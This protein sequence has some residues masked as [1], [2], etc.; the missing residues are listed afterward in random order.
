MANEPTAKQSTPELVG[1][2]SKE[3]LSDLEDLNRLY[4]SLTP[5]EKNAPAKDTRTIKQLMCVALC[6][7]FEMKAL[8]VRKA[9]ADN[10]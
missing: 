9:R 1:V 3:L 2:G 7:A 5:E 8:A 4:N 10:D 6:L